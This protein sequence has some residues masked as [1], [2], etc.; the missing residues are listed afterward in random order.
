MQLN[1]VL[2]DA[3]VRRHTAFRSLAALCGV[4][5]YFPTLRGSGEV[6]LVADAYDDEMARRGDTRRAWRGSR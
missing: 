2:I 3:L 1:Q 5:E 6:S 4:P